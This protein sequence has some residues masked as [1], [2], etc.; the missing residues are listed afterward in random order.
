M[1]GTRI[2]GPS[3]VVPYKLQLVTLLSTL[4]AKVG[5]RHVELAIDQVFGVAVPRNLGNKIQTLRRREHALCVVA[6]CAKQV[7]DDYSSRPIGIGCR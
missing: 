3:S 2:R 5:S 4:A 7:W 6:I 1:G